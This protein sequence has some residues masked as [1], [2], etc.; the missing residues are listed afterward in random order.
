M[1]IYLWSYVS[2]PI[3]WWTDWP[4]DIN[5]SFKRVYWSREVF[6][7][8]PLLC[9][10][11]LDTFRWHKLHIGSHTHVHQ[12]NKTLAGLFSA[13]YPPSVSCQQCIMCNW[14]HFFSHFTRH[15]QLK[16]CHPVYWYIFD[17]VCLSSRQI[18]VSH[19]ML[20]YLPGPNISFKVVSDLCY[21]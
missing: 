2:I 14:H 18:V 20:V 4:N 3:W 11:P 8:V 19:L 10:V 6:P 9:T 21:S 5:R 1:C 13:F 15:Y 7:L 12:A 17:T 16:F